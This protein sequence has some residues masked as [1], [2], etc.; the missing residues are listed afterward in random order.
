MPE[1]HKN[2]YTGYSSL[3]NHHLCVLY[4]CRLYIT[5]GKSEEA[6]S[7]YKQLKMYGDMVRLVKQYFPEHLDATHLQLAKVSYHA[8]SCTRAVYLSHRDTDTCI[9]TCSSLRYLTT[10]GIVAVV[11]CCT[12]TTGSASLMPSL[13]PLLVGTGGSWK[14]TPGGIPLDPGERLEICSEH[15]PQCWQVGRCLPHCQVSGWPNLG[16]EH[17]LFVGKASWR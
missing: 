11:H 4:M 8:H 1:G 14:Y 6:V 13:L 5:V 9:Y 2:H 16:Q 7:M 15:V 12:A 17:C 3:Q 10:I